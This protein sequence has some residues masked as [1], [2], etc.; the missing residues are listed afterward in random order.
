MIGIYKI[1]N[2]DTNKVYIGQSNDIKYRFRQHK[3]KLRANKH[4]NKYLQNAWNK[5][6]EKHFIFSVIE[7]CELKELNDKETYWCNYYKPNVYN[8]GNTGN[9]GTISEEIKQKLSKALK[10][11]KKSPELVEKNRLGH[12][13]L[14]HKRTKEQ[15]EKHRLKVKGRH[16]SPKTEFQKGHIV[17]DDVRKKISEASKGKKMNKKWCKNISKA[18]KGHSVSEE[19]R[20][21]I[22]EK[23]KGRK[24]SEETKTKM[25][26]RMFLL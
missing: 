20:K 9:V 18:K 21:K 16:L 3:C 13:G 22:S 14:K 23:L 7:E 4:Y 12:I 17:N 8:L 5:Y 24:L 26:G 6:G 19:T 15:I 10:G 1:T 2:I 25:L 11:R